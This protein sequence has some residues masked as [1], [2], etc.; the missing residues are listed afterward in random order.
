MLKYKLVF[1]LLIVFL[2]FIGTSKVLAAPCGNGV[3][4]S[5]QN[6]N[7]STCPIDCGICTPPPTPTPTLPPDNPT[8]TPTIVSTTPP[9]IP[10]TNQTPTPIAT[11]TSIPE[12]TSI[13]NTPTS[14]QTDTPDDSIQTNVN[15]TATPTPIPLPTIYTP[16]FPS[17]PVDQIITISGVTDSVLGIKS[18]EVS[19]DNGNNW[20]LA[21]LSGNRYQFTSEKLEDNNY[22]VKVRVTDNQNRSVTTNSKTVVVDMLPPI[23]GGSSLNLGSISLVPDSNGFFIVTKDSKLRYVISTKGG[24]VAGKVTLDKNDFELI[25]IDGTDLFYAE[26]IPVKKGNYKLEVYAVDGAKRETVRIMDNISIIESG[27]IVNSENNS[28]LTDSK[29]SVFYYEEDLKKWVLWNGNFFGQSNPKITNENGDYS[30]TL[31]FGRYYLE[32]T[33]KGFQKARSEIFEVEKTNFINFDFSLK[34]LKMVNLFNLSFYLPSFKPPDSFVITTENPTSDV[35]EIS[36]N[37]KE[38]IDI[39][40]D[41]NKY[42]DLS[43]YFGQDV[44]FS[45]ISSWSP[46]SSDLL[47]DLIKIKNDFPEKN[48]V[49]VFTQETP[50]FAA[51]FMKRG[52][53]KFDYIVDKNGYS[54]E[55]LEI[56][57]LPKTYFIGKDGFVEKEIYG[58]L[59][60]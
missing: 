58:S 25:K 52:S 21:R 18:V 7:C 35:K 36:F 60:D 30:F 4:Q 27:K 28:P 55:D 29:I 11:S 46:E 17:G 2:Y 44:I 33:K 6:E 14:N 43:A 54:L 40:I 57:Y 42:T 26:I 16:N 9:T 48:I 3:C 13:T 59:K 53:Y 32:I 50:G 23:I 10:P 56:S 15:P 1:L 49:C 51:S 5:S 8:P 38:T 31:P 39:K 45:F 19:L 37:P 20:F 41:K 24:V 47:R 22:L 34:P 12:A